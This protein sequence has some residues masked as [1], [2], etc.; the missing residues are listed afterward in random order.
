MTNVPDASIKV[1]LS[2]LWGIVIYR[3]IALSWE[4]G[5][6]ART[7]AAKQLAQRILS[8]PAAW[9]TVVDLPGLWVAHV[10]GAGGARRAYT[11]ERDA[12]VIL[13]K[14]FAKHSLADASTAASENGPPMDVRLDDA[15]STLLVESQGQ[16]LTDRYWGHYVAFLNDARKGQRWVLRDPTGGLPCYITK[17]AG[18]DVF[19]SDMED[20]AALELGRFS[21]NWEHLTA[22]FLYSELNTRHTGVHGVSQ[23]YAGERASIARDGETTRSFFWNPADVSERSVVED[24]DAARA[25]LGARIRHCVTA[26]TSGYEGVLQELSGGLD[27]SIVASCVAQAVPG[28]NVLGFHFFTDAPQGDERRY[29]RAVS[30]AAGIELREAECRLFTDSLRE[31]LDPLRVA[32]PSVLGFIPPSEHLRRRLVQERRVGAVFTGQGGDHLFQE[33]SSELVA[34]EFVHRHGLRAPL[35]KV[36]ADTSRL[37]QTSVWSVLA[38]ALSYGMLGRRFDAY[39]GYEQASPFLSTD[40]R[41]A[42]ARQAYAHPWVEQAT[43]LSAGKQRRVFNV[44]DCQ[45]FYLRPCHYA[46]LIHPLISQPIVELSLQIPGYVLAHRGKSRGLVREAFADQLPA[47]IVERYS[48]GGTTS[49]FNRMLSSDTTFLREFLLDGTL[50][51]HGLLDRRRLEAELEESALL[52]GDN[53][54]SLLDAVRAEAWLAA[55]S[56]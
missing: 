6:P 30:K 51:A 14:L 15:E 34:S 40:A 38:T 23:L 22:F 55:W 18:V 41:G 1:V 24:P 5:D 2:H 8:F 17:T 26:W 25:M 16:H 32:T 27:S 50:A 13:G 36:V 3:F 11:L 31:Q 9:R 49:Y 43:R 33:A 29:A 42:I 19:L 20:Y 46:E 21:P 4:S 28:D 52:R 35:L 7:A 47:E 54:R 37:T 12:G 10:Q 56:A 45:T 53:V 44:V 48:K 39:A